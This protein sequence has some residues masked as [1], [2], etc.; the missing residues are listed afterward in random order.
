MT[1]SVRFAARSLRRMWRTWDF[2][3][4]SLITR[5]DAI[6]AF[7]APSASS[8]EHLVLARRQ[9]RQAA[10]TT[11][12][13]R[14]GRR[15]RPAGSVD[16]LDV[17]A[18]ADALQPARRGAI[19]EVRQAGRERP[20]EIAIQDVELAIHDGIAVRVEQADDAIAADHR[21][22]DVGL[23][24]RRVH[25]RPVHV[26]ALLRVRDEDRELALDGLE[27]RRARRQLRVRGAQEA[28]EVRCGDLVAAPPGRAADDGVAGDVQQHRPVELERLAREARREVDEPAERAARNQ[29]GSAHAEP[30]AGAAKDRWRRY[31]EP[32]S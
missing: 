5:R 8:A 7:D 15:L 4:A 24:A 3:V 13:P 23:G 27:L 9:Q 29:G 2:T 21:R 1:A 16:R 32:P 12:T 18:P 25:Q 20:Q 26:V 10:R 31:R 17:G 11:A 14:T 22:D 19:D 6:V 30:N 28:G